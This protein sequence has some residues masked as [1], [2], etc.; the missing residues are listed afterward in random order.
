LIWRRVFVR[1]ILS[2]SLISS[3]HHRE[4]GGLL[5]DYGDEERLQSLCNVVFAIIIAQII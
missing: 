4:G 2:Y 1:V 5:E 3:Q